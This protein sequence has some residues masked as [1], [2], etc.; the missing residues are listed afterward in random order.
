CAPSPDDGVGPVAPGVDADLDLFGRGSLFQLMGSVQTS[1]G[2]FRLRD[3]LLRPADPETIARR[4]EAVADWA[5]ALDARQEL[6]RRGRRTTVDPRWIGRFVDW[7][8][9]DFFLDRRPALRLYAVIAPLMLFGFLTLDFFDVVSPW[10]WIF[11]VMANI[12][13]SF[14]VCGRI[15]EIF[16]QIDGRRR[17]VKHYETLF[18]AVVALPHGVAWTQDRRAALNVDGGATVNFRRLG[19][20]CD[21]ACLRFSSAFLAIQTVLLWDFQVLAAA[22]RWK[23]RQ[24]ANVR[25]WFDAVADAEA[26]AALAGLKHDHPAWA[27]PNVAGGAAAKLQAAG[28]GHPLLPEA[29]RVCNDV[30]IGPP[31]TML[32]V[33]G[34]NMS[35]KSTLLRAVGLNALLAQA[36][37]VV[38]AASWTM[39]PLVVA[40]SM[41]ISD[42]L[43]AGVSLFFAEL[44]RL[45]EIVDLADAVRE[46][47][48]GGATLL[49]LL[50]E[51]LQGTNS[52][53]RRICVLHVLGRLIER[54][55][56]GAA[57]THDL[58][59]AHHPA[60]ASAVQPF[61][62]RESFATTPAG[63]IMTFDYRLQPGVA[64][65]T[66]AVK[67]LELVGL[68][69][70]KAEIEGI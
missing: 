40:T 5:P 48:A 39:T 68:G 12:V 23:R 33:T 57:S 28:V 35:G 46:P 63:E 61:H 26:L 44:R 11:V 59:L 52:A 55:A 2:R 37:G 25:R 27:F 10:C 4:Q 34:S 60:V 32:L 29:D 14:Q 1:G 56:I 62:F 49:F 19:R 20:V 3:W 13:V 7:A 70:T 21:L 24:R 38:C 31:G 45:R 64:T 54:G 50:D 42:S 30:T 9:G 16:D 18:D 41:R 17:A 47:A 53:E 6:E 51:I 43:A 58:E 67:L 65:T 36:G 15:H 69:S 22:E 66:N 8:E